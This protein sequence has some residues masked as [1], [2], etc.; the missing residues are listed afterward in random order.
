MAVIN[1]VPQEM[2]NVCGPAEPGVAGVCGEDWGGEGCLLPDRNSKK[3]NPTKVEKKKG[4]S[5]KLRGSKKS[6]ALQSSAPS[7]ILCD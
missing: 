3:K 7:I 6:V 4:V 1:R 5:V 2:L